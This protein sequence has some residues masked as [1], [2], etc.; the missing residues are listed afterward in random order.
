MKL[1]LFSFHSAR[2]RVRREDT[3]SVLREVSRKMCRVILITVHNDENDGGPIRLINRL[4]YDAGDV[5]IQLDER[6]VDIKWAVLRFANGGFGMR[7][8]GSNVGEP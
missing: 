6:P 3:V 8:T 7:A 2:K 5:P 1:S 4:I